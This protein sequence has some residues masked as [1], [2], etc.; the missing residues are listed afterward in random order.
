MSNEGENKEKKL[1]KLETWTVA[2]GLITSLI[3]LVS[4]IINIHK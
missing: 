2:L 1:S 3:N 4:S